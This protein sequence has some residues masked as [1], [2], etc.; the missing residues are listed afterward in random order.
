MK[1]LAFLCNV[2]LLLFTSFVL[3]TDGF[4][5]N[6][7]YIIFTICVFFTIFLNIIIIYR[8][9]FKSFLISKKIRTACIICNAIFFFFVIWAAVDQ[10]PHPAEAGFLPFLFLMT[11]TPILSLF[12]NS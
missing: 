5:V 3:L 10:Y 12:A 11:L 8:M 1:T 2:I 4:P 9:I 7:V 6:S